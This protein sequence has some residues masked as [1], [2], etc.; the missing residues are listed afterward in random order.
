M[1]G[2]YHTHTQFSLDSEAPIPAM[3]ER[4]IE[5]GLSHICF[6]DHMDMDYPEDEDFT[7]DTNLYFREMREYQSQYADRIKVL[8]GVELGLQPHLANTHAAYLKQYPFDY[9]IGS[10]HLVNNMDPY[11]DKAFEG[12]TDEEVFRCYF[13][14]TLKNVQAFHEFDSMGHLD[15][16]VRYGRHGSQEYSYEK[17]KD[18]IDEILKILVANGKA[19]EV[20]TAGLRKNLGFPNPHGKIVRRYHELGGEMITIGSDAHK[21]A[22]MGYG[23]HQ[24]KDILGEAGFHQ[25]V[26]FENRK[27]VFVDL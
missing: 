21:P 19:L 12:R 3:I 7:F 20:N 15:Y 2:D 18:I 27:P 26:R 16:V 24:L 14:D 10:V 6:T 22:Q 25:Y 17:F 8:I 23:F 9:V 4:A 11:F 13:E 1:L 5:L